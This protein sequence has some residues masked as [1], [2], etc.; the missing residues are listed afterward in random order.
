VWLLP[1]LWDL[2]YASFSSATL[3]LSTVRRVDPTMG[4]LSAF[5]LTC[6]PLTELTGL[7]LIGAS[8]ETQESPVSPRACSWRE[9]E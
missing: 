9:Y 8:L 4:W 1:P 6:R 5:H 2:C 7:D 3:A